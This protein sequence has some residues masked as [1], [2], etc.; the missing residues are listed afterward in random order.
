[1]EDG[2]THEFHAWLLKVWLTC[3]PSRTSTSRTSTYHRKSIYCCA[4]RLTSWQRFARSP[5]TSRA[6]IRS[7]AALDAMTSITNCNLSS[8][9]CV[10]YRRGLKSRK[11]VDRNSHFRAK[12]HIASSRLCRLPAVVCDATP[13]YVRIP[14]CTARTEPLSVVRHCMNRAHSTSMRAMLALAPTYFRDIFTYSP[15]RA[16]HA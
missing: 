9:H 4:N 1:M 15:S 12:T 14:R 5:W 2:Q 10:T 6:A 13:L 3:T 8:W 11:N 7:A 16:Y